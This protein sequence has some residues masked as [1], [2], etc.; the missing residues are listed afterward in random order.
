MPEKPLTLIVGANGC[1][2]TTII[3]CLKA[4]TTG[5]LPP[6]SQRG[7]Y[8]VND[9]KVPLIFLK[10]RLLETLKSKPKLDYNS[11]EPTKRKCWLFVHSN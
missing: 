11:K 2:K 1:G 8:F 4:A 9:P 6:N 10:S 5:E 3:E 7:Q